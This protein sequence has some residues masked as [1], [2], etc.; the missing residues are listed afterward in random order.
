MPIPSNFP[1]KPNVNNVNF[2]D[3]KSVMNYQQA[4]QRYNFA[5][6]ALQQTQNEEATTKTNMSKSNHDALMAMINNTKA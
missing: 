1:T 6:Q 5:L 2:D 3:E 4:M